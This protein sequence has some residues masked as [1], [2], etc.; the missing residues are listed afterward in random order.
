MRVRK[1]TDGVKR[2]KIQI[3]HHISLYDLSV[4]FVA[5]V[6]Y[7]PDQTIIEKSKKMSKKSIMD[8]IKYEIF[9]NGEEIPNYKVS[10][11]NKEQLQEAV[12][13]IFKTRFTEF[14]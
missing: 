1:Y 3:N 9:S 10:D 4:F 12:E 11:E 5:S 14:N 6:C 7:E 2:A 8:K 13:E